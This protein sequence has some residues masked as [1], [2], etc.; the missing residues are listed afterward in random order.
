MNAHKLITH[1]R[2][3]LQ[4]VHQLLLVV[5]VVVPVRELRGRPGVEVEDEQ[6]GLLGAVPRPDGADQLGVAGPD[7]P[8][9]TAAPSGG[10]RD[11]VADELA[12]GGGRE[13]SLCEIW[14]HCGTPYQ[15]LGACDK[16]TLGLQEPCI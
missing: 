7:P 4:G 16:G 8:H 15:L 11:Q 10:Q 12:C 13:E 2:L 3:H 9:H 5:V 14:R 1:I 6:L